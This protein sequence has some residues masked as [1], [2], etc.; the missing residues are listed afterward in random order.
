MNLELTPKL[1][2]SIALVASLKEDQKR[3]MFDLMKQ[4]YE[5]VD[6][7]SFHRDLLKTYKVILLATC[8]GHIRGFSTLQRLEVKIGGRRFCGMFSGDTVLE[9]QFWGTRLLGKIFLKE[10]FFEKLKSPFQ[11]LYWL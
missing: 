4:Y 3:S 7:E 6:C 8:V 2:G 9:K 10:L 1:K 11:P 5:Q